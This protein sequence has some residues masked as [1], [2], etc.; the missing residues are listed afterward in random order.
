MTSTTGDA[1]LE[2]KLEK[3]SLSE[4]VAKQQK[5]VEEADESGNEEDVETSPDVHF[6][7]I[8]HLEAVETKTNEEDEAV[9]YGCRAKLYRFDKRESE[10]KER[11]VGEVRLLQHRTTHRVRLVMRRD[12]TL[13][14]CA[15]HSVIP[16]I[17]LKRNPSSEKSW[18]YAVGADISEGEPRPELFAFRFANV[19]T[20]MDFKKN[21]ESAQ[22]ASGEKSLISEE[23]DT[24]CKKTSSAD[25]C[26]EKKSEKCCKKDESF[27]GCCKKDVSSVGYCK[28]DESSGGCCKKDESSV[29]CCKKDES[30]G[31]SKKSELDGCC[32][33]DESSGGCCK[34]SSVSCSKK[35]SAV[36]CCKK[37]ESKCC[38]KE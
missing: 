9:I 38:K 13:K 16:S 18:V 7:P 33:K 12:Q 11:G 21:F 5:P 32:K 17:Q 25:F 28:N 3:M 29:G 37:S 2:K 6:E 31:C 35:S 4:L 27:V 34:K 14:V 26:G 19:E 8:V 36:G 15:N 30:T 20:T 10:W 1:P 24:C 23:L 22:T